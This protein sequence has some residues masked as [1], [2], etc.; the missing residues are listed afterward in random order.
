MRFAATLFVGLLVSGALLPG[1]AEAGRRAGK[2]QTHVA[3]TLIAPGDVARPQDGQ[4]EFRWRGNADRTVLSHYEFRLYKGPQ[5][6][7]PYLIMKQE[8][9][10]G[11]ES[12]SLP[13]S[14][15]EPGQTYSWSVKAA[16]H[17]GKGRSASS[18]F[19][20]PDA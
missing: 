17:A 15:F 18:V 9:T 19:R 2:D 7:E 4:L 12:L 10:D 8:V 14:T 6:Y 11:K 1:E 13:V 3:P 16:L 20:T 5:S